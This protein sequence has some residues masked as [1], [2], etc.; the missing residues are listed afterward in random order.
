MLA[1]PHVRF[2]LAT[3]SALAPHPATN[4]DIPFS[5]LALVAIERVAARR[6]ADVPGV[7]IRLLGLD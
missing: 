4:L 1:L 2:G 6:T 7:L 3:W 5:G